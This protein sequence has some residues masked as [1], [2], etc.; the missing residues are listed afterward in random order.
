MVKKNHSRVY[1]VYLLECVDKSIYT[2]ITTDPDRRL[3]EHLDGKA[4]K[5]TRAHQAKRIIYLEK[6][7]DKSGALKREVEIK[8]WSKEKKLELISKE[9]FSKANFLK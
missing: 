3:Q 8:G 7:K 4:S 2:G 5:Y 9:D 1:F 6:Q